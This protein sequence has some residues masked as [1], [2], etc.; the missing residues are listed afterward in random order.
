[1][2]VSTQSAAIVCVYIFFL[3]KINK[4]FY[5]QMFSVAKFARAIEMAY[6]T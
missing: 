2:K 4:I 5:S 6:I 1:M 3:F